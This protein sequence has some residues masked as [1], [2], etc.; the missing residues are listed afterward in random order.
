MVDV[1][2]DHYIFSPDIVQLIESAERT[3]TIDKVTQ[4]ISVQYRRELDNALAMM[5]KF[6]EPVALLGAGVFVLWFA[7]AIFTVVMQITKSAGVL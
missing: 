2:A 4:K 7:M 6:I 3:S 1:N 5:V